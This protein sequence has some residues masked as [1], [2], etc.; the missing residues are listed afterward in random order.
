MSVENVEKVIRQAVVDTSFREQLLA[1]PDEALAGFDL[2][3]RERAIFT[4]LDEGGL[5]AALVE[6]DSGEL[7]ER[8]SRGSCFN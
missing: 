6:A 1:R 8:V 2:T 4:D 7:E 3:D 5:Q